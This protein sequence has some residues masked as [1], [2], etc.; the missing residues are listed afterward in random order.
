VSQHSTNFSSNQ[1][2]GKTPDLYN[3]L[4]MGTNQE[5][6]TEFK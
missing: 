2:T 4:P 6:L 5:T 3:K 1:A